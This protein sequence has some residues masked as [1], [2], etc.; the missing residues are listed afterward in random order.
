MKKFCAKSVNIHNSMW[1]HALISHRCNPL[2]CSGRRKYLKVDQME[3]MLSMSPNM[4]MGRKMSSRHSKTTKKTWKWDGPDVGK[5][6][7]CVC[8]CVTQHPPQPAVSNLLPSCGCWREE[9][10][11]FY[12]EQVSELQRHH[13]ERPAPWSS[14]L[15]QEDLAAQQVKSKH[16]ARIK[17]E[18]LTCHIQNYISVYIVTSFIAD[19]H[20]INPKHA[21]WFCVE[22]VSA[23]LFLQIPG[24]HFESWQDPPDGCCLHY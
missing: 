7:L 23:F 5:I 15:H 13:W 18:L 20:V 21:V 4:L 9:R 22:L 2:A 12:L 17:H 6:T 1:G 16:G 8:V 24:L 14:V 10:V 11:G 19:M 3:K